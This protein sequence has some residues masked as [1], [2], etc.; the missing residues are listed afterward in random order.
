VK[1]RVRTLT[2]GEKGKKRRSNEKG[3][4][5]QKDSKTHH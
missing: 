2:E 4:P 1:H 3:A 5:A